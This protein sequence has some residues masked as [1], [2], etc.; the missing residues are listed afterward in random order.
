MLFGWSRRRFFFSENQELICAWQT[1]FSIISR[2]LLLNTATSI[3]Y[4]R[5]A[6]F[7][8]NETVVA[9]RCLKMQPNFL[10]SLS[11]PGTPSTPVFLGIMGDVS[12]ASVFALFPTFC[13]RLD[14]FFRCMVQYLWSSKMQL[15]SNYARQKFVLKKDNV[16]PWERTNWWRSN[17]WS[18]FRHFIVHSAQFCGDFQRFFR[19]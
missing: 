11:S 6:F 17:M 14:A 15:V 1:Y 12:D 7:S 9:T 8:N 13:R 16:P 2:L 18:V 10:H 19:N 4:P 5:T 3:K